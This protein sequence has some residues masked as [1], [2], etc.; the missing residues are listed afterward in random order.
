[1]RQA[2]ALNNV[3]SDPCHYIA[4][5]VHNELTMNL[6]IKCYCIHS[7]A[8]KISM[9]VG[10]RVCMCIHTVYVFGYVCCP[11]N[12]YSWNL[13]LSHSYAL[14][15]M[16]VSKR[17][18]MCIYIRFPSYIIVFIL[19]AFLP[20]GPYHKQWRPAMFSWVYKSCC[21][22]LVLSQLVGQQVNFNFNIKI[23]YLTYFDWYKINKYKNT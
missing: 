2:S 10:K 14:I 16:C 3:D 8:L 4:S 9:H 22:P 12:D 20:I 13:M 21:V 11:G 15:S 17:V 6:E 5:P 19:S 1:M 23:V 18:C 7:Y